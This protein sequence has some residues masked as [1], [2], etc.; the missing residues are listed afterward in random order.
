MKIM[1]APVRGPEYWSY[2]CLHC[3]NPVRE[4]ASLW[5]RIIWQIKGNALS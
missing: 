5:Q 2:R 3:G 4:H 1:H